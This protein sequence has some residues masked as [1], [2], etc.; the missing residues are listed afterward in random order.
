MFE[1]RAF[2]VLEIRWQLLRS[3]PVTENHLGLLQAM[4]ITTPKNLLEQCL[5]MYA[6]EYADGVCVCT[7]ILLTSCVG[8]YVLACASLCVRV[9]GS[10]TSAF[11][12]CLSFSLG[13]GFYLNFQ[14]L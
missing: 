5:C 2:L 10:L 12:F 11:E 8:A 13:I 1:E 4:Q 3:S 7:H 9:C 14:A 6:C